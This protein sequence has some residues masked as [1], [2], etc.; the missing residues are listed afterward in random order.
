MSKRQLLALLGFWVI[1]FLYLGFPTGW[2]KWIAIITGVLIILVAYK[3]TPKQKSFADSSFV[4]SNMRADAAVSPA[5]NKP[6]TTE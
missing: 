1:I 2:D 6:T 3:K 5:E 4:Q